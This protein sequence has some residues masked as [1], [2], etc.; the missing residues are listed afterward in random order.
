[1]KIGNWISLVPLATGNFVQIST[2]QDSTLNIM[3]ARTD[4]M[5]QA[6]WRGLALIHRPLSRK[7]HMFCVGAVTIPQRSL[8]A[9]GDGL[10]NG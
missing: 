2:N 4:F 5:V 3:K 10:E 1:M 8:L 6:L 9:R 7:N